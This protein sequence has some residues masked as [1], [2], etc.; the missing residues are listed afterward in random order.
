ME[1]GFCS[2]YDNKDSKTGRAH[3]KHLFCSS[4]IFCQWQ[5]LNWVK[6]FVRQAIVYFAIS[7]LVSEVRAQSCHRD[8][9]AE[10]SYRCLEC[11]QQHLAEQDGVGPAERYT[12][13]AASCI[14]L[15]LANDWERGSGPIYT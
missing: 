5:Q 9:V 10:V 7:C 14:C 3:C 1:A 4:C 11:F 8:S 2:A 15:V 6:L 12:Q 13:Q